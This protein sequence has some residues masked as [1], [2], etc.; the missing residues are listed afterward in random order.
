LQ[1]VD[2]AFRWDIHVDAS[3]FEA[4]PIPEGYA[5]ED[6]FPEP[7]DEENAIEG[8]R[9]CVELF[10]D[11][12]EKIDLTYLWAESENS[13]T[14][15]ALRLKEGLEGLAGLERD[16]KKMDAL[17]PIRVLSKFYLELG[18][19]DPAYHGETAQPGEAEKVLLRW[20]L[21]DG[22]YRVIFGDLSA[23]TVTTDQLAELEGP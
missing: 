6:D 8:L 20:R 12:P 4:P 10:D 14:A 2:D 5:I 3:E 13:E 1:Q 19:K 9:Q 22:Q 15:T 16:N 11:Y 7:A 21:D 23:R 17:K 18:E